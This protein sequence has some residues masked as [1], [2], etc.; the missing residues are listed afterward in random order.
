MAS[1]LTRYG[2]W[3]ACCLSRGRQAPI[4]G[5]ELAE[6]ADE[7]GE[8]SFAGGTF[9]FHQGDDAAR[10]HIV[11][12]GAVELSRQLHNRL[13]RVTAYYYRRRV[14]VSICLLATRNAA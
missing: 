7:L 1:I 10:V 4:G 8:E 6:L 13:A 12:S 11:R 14:P 9:V 2:T 3:I 5:R